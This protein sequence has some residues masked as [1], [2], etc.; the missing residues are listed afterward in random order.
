VLR[1]ANRKLAG[2]VV[3][4]DE[5]PVANAY[6]NMYGS[7][8]PSSSVRTDSQGRFAFDAVCEGMVRLSASA[9]SSHGTT[10]AEAGET[11]VVVQLGSNMDVVS[12]TPRR[13]SLKGRALPDLAPFG[14]PAEAAATGKPLLLCLLDAEQRPSRRTARLLAEQHDALRQKG[15]L[16]LAV[17]ASAASAESFQSWTNSSPLPFPV[18][19][20]VEKSATTRWASEVESLP[21][22]ILRD[23]D[24]KVAAEGFALDELDTKVSALKK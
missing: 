5:K 12:A 10:S 22:F 13:P 7:G 4:T 3:D 21:W 19:R 18:G 24:G 20:I 9:Q 14:L 2:Q 8:Q 15:I 11:N 17:Q 16:V 1:V 6:V 23:A